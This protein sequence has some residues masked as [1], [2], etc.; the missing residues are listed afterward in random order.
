MNYKAVVTVA[1][2]VE[3]VTLDEAKD[4]LRIGTDFTLDDTYISGLINSARDRVEEYCNR[5]FTEQQVSLVFDGGFPSGSLTLPYPD[6]QTVD[7]I[8]YLDSGNT[9]QTVAGGDYFVDLI[10]QT[11]YLVGSWPGDAKNYRINVTTGSP[12]DNEGVK[13]S[14]LMIVADLY[15]HRTE[16]VLA[17]TVSENPAVTAMLYP[18]RVNLGI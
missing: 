9:L 15:E 6:L 1:A 3:P 14:I 18:Y 2:S 8:Q 10:S 17:A 7:S 13:A 12:L 16:T 11:V 5:F 4:Q